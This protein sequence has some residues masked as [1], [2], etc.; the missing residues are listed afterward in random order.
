MALFLTTGCQT[1]LFGATVLL[2]ISPALAQVS[3]RDPNMPDPKTTIP[4]KI[5]PMDPDTTGS[6][7]SPSLS[8]KLNRSEGVIKPGGHVD[9]DLRVPAPVP[10]PGTT[11]VIPPPGSPGGDQRI[12]L[13]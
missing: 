2:T 1:W 8:E 5:Q 9:P 4:E 7:S 6:T 3:V 11:L 10:N 13:K 12:Q